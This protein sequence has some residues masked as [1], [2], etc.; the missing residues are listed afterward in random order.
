[1]NG[2]LRLTRTISPGVP[3]ANFNDGRNRQMFIF[4]NPK[5]IRI[6]E[7]V[8]PKKNSLLFSIPKNPWCFCIKFYYL[9][10]GKLRHG[11]V[12][13]DFGQT[14]N[15]TGNIR[16]IPQYHTSKELRLYYLFE[17]IKKSLKNCLSF[18]DP[19]KFRR[20]LFKNTTKPFWSKAQTQNNPPDPSPP[21][22]IM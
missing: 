9:S 6:S 22:V 21:P 5:K 4:Y 16:N 19:K 14:Q 17:L 12:N 20:R 1:M 11:N 13:F 15:Y 2:K 18:R 7:F 8:Y 3:L 10:S